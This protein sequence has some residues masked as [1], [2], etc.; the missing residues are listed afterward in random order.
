MYTCTHIA[1]MNMC[2]IYIYIYICIYIYTHMHNVSMYYCMLTTQLYTTTNY[3]I[4]IGFAVLNR[5]TSTGRLHGQHDARG[6][7]LA[8]H[9]HHAERRP[10]GLQRQIHCKIGCHELNWAV[11]FTPMPMLTR[12]CR[13]L[14]QKRAQ[15]KACRT[16]LGRGMVI[17]T[18]AQ[19]SKNPKS[20]SVP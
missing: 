6:V 4:L 9:R 10:R 12:A 13:T 7:A 2:I 18:T 17:N 20:A 14:T 8:V 1:I 3:I 5:S 11:T 16:C 15:Y 19:N